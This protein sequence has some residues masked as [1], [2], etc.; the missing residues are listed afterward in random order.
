MCD[1]AEL[2]AAWDDFTEEIAYSAGVYTDYMQQEIL[3]LV[4]KAAE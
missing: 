2:D 1:P 3:K 4:E